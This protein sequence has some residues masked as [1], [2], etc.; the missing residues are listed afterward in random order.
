MNLL[1]DRR[2]II[3]VTSYYSDVDRFSRYHVGSSYLDKLLYIL[4][5]Y[6]FRVL[7]NIPLMKYSLPLLSNF[8]FD[9]I[10]VISI[11]P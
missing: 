1:R 9:D 5:I 11:F 10:N 6:I 3:L 2:E 4:Y 8:E 7:S